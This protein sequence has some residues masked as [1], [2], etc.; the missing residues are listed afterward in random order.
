MNPR[1]TGAI[2]FYEELALAGF[3]TAPLRPG[4]LGLTERAIS[5]CLFS[6]DSRLLDLGCGNG[7]TVEH[8]AS[9]WGLTAVGLDPSPLLLGYGTRRGKGLPYVRAVGEHLPFRRGMWDGILLECVLSVAGDANAVIAECA[10][11]LKVGGHLI[12]T[13]VYLR[14]AWDTRA[15]ENIPAD[16]CL[17]RALERTK[18]ESSLNG[19][20]FTTVLWEDH[21]KALKEFAAELIL[22]GIQLNMARFSPPGKDRARA[23]RTVSPAVPMPGKPGYFLLVARLGGRRDAEAL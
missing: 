18:L 23:S 16:C 5:L 21:S 10:R 13:D 1:C 4:G 17:A 7:A 20:G 14:A 8:L 9:K 19:C 22:A 15:P 6:Q 11:V 3:H 2:P 12:I